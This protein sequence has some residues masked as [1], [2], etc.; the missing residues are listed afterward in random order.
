MYAIQEP[1]LGLIS[2]LFASW[3][4][5]RRNNP[6][7]SLWTDITIQQIIYIAFA[8]CC[9]TILILWLPKNETYM[10]PIYLAYR[11]IAISLISGFFVMIECFTFYNIIVNRQN[12]I[13]NV[14]FIYTLVLVAIST[15]VLSFMLGPISAVAYLKYLNGSTPSAWIKYGA[16]YYLI[17]RII[18]Q[19]IK[20]PLEALLMTSLILTIDPLVNRM[21]TNIN[22]RWK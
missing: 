4:V 13:R 19:S 6:K 21:L 5:Y 16:V 14:T 7:N 18:V 1:I 2:G 20:T 8:A 15:L 17:P 10:T 3:C 12:K 22:N 9:Y 11:W